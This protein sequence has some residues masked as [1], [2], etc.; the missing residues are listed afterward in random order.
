MIEVPLIQFYV[1]NFFIILAV[2]SLYFNF[3]KVNS[4]PL[5]SKYRKLNEFNRI[6]DEW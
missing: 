6:C 4:I 3:T 2:E 1:Y 5:I